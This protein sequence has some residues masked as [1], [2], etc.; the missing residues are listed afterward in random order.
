MY[1]TPEQRQLLRDASTIGYLR[2]CLKG[3]KWLVPDAI[4]DKIDA[5]LIRA[6]ELQSGEPLSPPIGRLDIRKTE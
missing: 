5:A 3:L 4:R 6:D 1:F 2:G